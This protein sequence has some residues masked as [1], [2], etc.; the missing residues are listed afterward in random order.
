HL[1]GR[2][3]ELFRFT[4]KHS[5]IM[6]IF[7]CS[8]VLAQ[9]YLF[10]FLIP[11]YHVGEGTAAASSSS[12]NEGLAYL[13]SLVVVLIAIALVIIVLNRNKVTAS[14]NLKAI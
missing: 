12:I 4:V 9:A 10:Q 13:L 7:I 5:F 14:E 2:E 3:S 11:T 8:I 1:V 6:L